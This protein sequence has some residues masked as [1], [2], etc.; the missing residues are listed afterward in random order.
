MAKKAILLDLDGTIW[1]SY[2]W[3][4]RILSEAAGGSIAKLIQQ[5]RAG[6]SVMSMC[7]A[8]GLSA[9]NFRSNALKN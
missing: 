3:Y 5:L 8:C 9:S 4:A 6:N 7:N 2:S 1:E